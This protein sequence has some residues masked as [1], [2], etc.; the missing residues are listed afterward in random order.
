MAAT[1]WK[2]LCNFGMVS[3]PVK[4]HSAA[5][6]ETVSFNLLHASDNSRIKQITYCQAEDKPIARGET[7]KGYEYEKDRYVVIDEEDIKKVAPKSSKVMEIL[8]FVPAN[9]VDPVYLDSSYYVHP[10][11]GGE[12]PY[13]L[14]LQALRAEGKCAVAKLAMHNREHTVIIRP[15]KTGLV[16]HTMFYQDEVRAVEEFRTD[17]GLVKDKE[18]AMARMLVGSMTEDFQP[19]K[20]HDTFRENLM[21]LIE[22]KKEGRA[23]QATPEEPA[24]APIFDILEALRASV[25]SKTAGKKK[26]KVA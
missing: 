22:T 4:L 14:L 7:V 20:Y 23:A 3:F 18:L 25:E 16:L 11:S 10:D 15:G 26:R 5:R 19:E 8:E 2:G 21:A 1:V 6:S 13:G 17:T 12:K 9:S 24:Q